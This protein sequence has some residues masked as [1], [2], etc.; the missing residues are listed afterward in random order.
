MKK[1][2][3]TG[4]IAAMFVAIVATPSLACPD[5]NVGDSWSSSSGGTWILS[6]SGADSDTGVLTAGYSNAIVKWSL[7]S[8]VNDCDVTIGSDI[9]TSIFSAS[10]GT[11]IFLFPAEAVYIDGG[12]ISQ[13]ADTLYRLEGTGRLAANDLPVNFYADLAWEHLAGDVFGGPH[14]T[15]SGTIQEIG[16]TV[17]PLPGTLLMFG[18]GLIGLLCVRRRLLHA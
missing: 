5:L 14:L 8:F 3:F 17:I 18:T 4:I 16:L 11:G 1:L 6:T 7:F 13:T 15:L 2:F 10:F 9:G 12:G